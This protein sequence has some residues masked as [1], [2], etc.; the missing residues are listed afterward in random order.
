MKLVSAINYRTLLL[1]LLLYDNKDYVYVISTQDD[2]VA[3]KLEANGYVVFNMKINSYLTG[4]KKFCEQCDIQ[5]RFHKFLLEH[6]IED[7]IEEYIGF[8]HVFTIMKFMKEDCKWT[9]LE[10]GTGNYESI[11]SLKRIFHQSFIKKIAMIVLGQQKF[12]D[13]IPFG[14]NE[15]IDRIILTGILPVPKLLKERTSLVSLNGL[16]NN[17]LEN[18]RAFIN[19]LFSFEPDR[20]D[21]KIVVLTQVFD[22]YDD[23]S[24]LNFYN[25]YIKDSDD[26][27][28]KIHPREQDCYSN[29]YKNVYVDNN[30]W[31][32]ELLLLNGVIPKKII[33]IQSTA[34]KEY[35]KI[36]NVEYIKPDFKFYYE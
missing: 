15:L 22:G 32:F 9:V 1:A 8:D 11:D 30:R 23:E 20:Y 27:V 7:S 16:W 29:S 35:E 19:N 2:N 3:K 28:I 24:K 33:T 36:C 14:Y 6:K 18:K 12:L 5:K 34:A 31:P 17:A 26:Y 4:F 25:R 10:E 21:D 13:Y